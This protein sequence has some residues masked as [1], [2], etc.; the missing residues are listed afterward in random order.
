[1][2][3]YIYLCEEVSTI[4]GDIYAQSQIILKFVEKIWKYIT[5]FLSSVWNFL[6]L[7]DI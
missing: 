1:M 2:D 5:E 6:V 7:H 4:G 3:E